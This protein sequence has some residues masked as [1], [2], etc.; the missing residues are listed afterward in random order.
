MFHHVYV[1]FYYVFLLVLCNIGALFYPT[2]NG[3]QLLSTCLSY[4]NG[5]RSQLPKV[6]WIS[7]GK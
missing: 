4:Y 7:V 3:F 6:Q 2:T 1:L 5:L